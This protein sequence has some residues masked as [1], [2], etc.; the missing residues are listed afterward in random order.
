MVMK[1]YFA[2]FVALCCI[3]G[4]LSGQ[5]SAEESGKATG[6]QREAEEQLKEELSAFE[7][8]ADQRELAA[9]NE[10]N[11]EGPGKWTWE[12]ADTSEKAESSKPTAIPGKGCV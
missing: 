1:K 6:L 9:K 8:T 5:V 3:T 4:L 10:A 12:H 7:I 11:A 2:L